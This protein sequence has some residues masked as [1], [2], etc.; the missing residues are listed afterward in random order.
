MKSNKAKKI[1]DLSSLYWNKKEELG[2]C[3]RAGKRAE[4]DRAS[5]EMK[6]L[7]DSVRDL[8]AVGDQIKVVESPVSVTGTIWVTIKSIQKGR[9][10]PVGL[11][12]DNGYVYEGG[13]VL[14]IK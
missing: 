4:A 6:R 5:A 14:E 3:C 1:R 2:E 8:V 10:S 12:C 9:I 11:C 13:S 7:E